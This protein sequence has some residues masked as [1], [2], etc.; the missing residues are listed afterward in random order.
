MFA[1][2]LGFASSSI[3]KR[4]GP[5]GDDISVGIG[6]GVMDFGVVLY[7]NRVSFDIIFLDNIIRRENGNLEISEILGVSYKIG[8]CINVISFLL[9]FLGVQV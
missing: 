1:L 7:R 8:I 2:S 4:L 6:L 5:L 9:R 3:F